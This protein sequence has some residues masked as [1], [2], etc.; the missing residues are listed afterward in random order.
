MSWKLFQRKQCRLLLNARKEILHSTVGIIAFCVSIS[1]LCLHSKSCFRCTNMRSK[2]KGFSE[3]QLERVR[4]LLCLDYNAIQTLY[5]HLSHP[6]TLSYSPSGANVFFK[7]AAL[8]GW[9][10]SCHA[11][12]TLRDYFTGDSQH[13]WNRKFCKWILTIVVFPFFLASSWPR[14]L[15]LHERREKKKPWID[16]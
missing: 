16:M 15:C 14:Q 2:L 1:C 10:A 6:S 4:I 11:T 8:R 13:S 12:S 7:T 5:K 9:V 3:D